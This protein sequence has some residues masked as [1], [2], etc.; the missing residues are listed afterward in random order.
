MTATEASLYIDSSKLTQEEHSHLGETVKIRPYS[1]IFEETQQLSQ[2]LLKPENVDDGTPPS[3][4]PRFLL[5]T[6]ASWALTESLGGEEKVE[7]VRSPVGDAKAV[8]NETEIAGM[9]ACHTRDGA[10]LIEFFAWLEDEL[11]VKRTKLDE[12]QAAD[13]LEKIRS[14]VARRLVG[15]AVLTAKQEARSLC[16]LVVFDHLCDRGQ[17][18]G[19]PLPSGTT[20]LC[21]DRPQASL[22]LRLWCAVSRWNHRHDQDGTLSGA[23]GN[24]TKV[25]YVG[26][27]G[28]HRVGSFGVPERSQRSRA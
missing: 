22:S 26:A 9:K 5:P 20:R 4:R 21:D 28:K 14:Y 2:S 15:F 13:R 16:R 27:Q 11:V 23:D 3:P 6:T 1:G 10:A 25:L 8:K 19:H 17:C 12:V 24:G 7:E 18:C